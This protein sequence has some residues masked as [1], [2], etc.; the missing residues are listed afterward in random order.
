MY[1]ALPPCAAPKPFGPCK[2]FTQGRCNREDCPFDHILSNSYTLT[3]VIPFHGPVWAIAVR[4]LCKSIAILNIS[5]LT[6]CL[7]TG[8]RCPTTQ[9][10][11][12]QIYVSIFSAG[13]M[14]SNTLSL[15]SRNEQSKR[16]RWAI[17]FP[18]SAP[19]RT[20]HRTETYGKPV[21]SSD[22]HILKSAA[23]VIRINTHRL[24]MPPKKIQFSLPWP[25]ILTLAAK[26]YPIKSPSYETI[27]AL[28]FTLGWERSS[29]NSQQHSNLGLLW[30]LMSLPT[31]LAWPS[32]SLP[33]PLA[34]LRASLATE[35]QP[36]LNIWTFR[37]QRMRLKVSAIMKLDNLRYLHGLT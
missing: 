6:A 20:K 37:M 26:V 13:S 7:F 34:R 5:G 29:R 35:H 21:F 8:T 31:Q 14:Y 32:L 10:T 28:K 9:T 30:C 12:I 36:G 25:R 3:S 19:E 11:V 17:A 16:R 24:L 1:A 4:I 23:D 22:L 33:N 27:P 18:F 2:F 15:S